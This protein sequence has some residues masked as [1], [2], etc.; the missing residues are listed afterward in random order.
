MATKR[1][2]L[3][4]QMM[5]RHTERVCQLTNWGHVRCEEKWAKYGALWYARV[6]WYD[7]RRML[8]ASLVTN[9]LIGARMAVFFH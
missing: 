3:W 7:V 9:T 2:K 4:V 5:M 1:C 6:A 8:M